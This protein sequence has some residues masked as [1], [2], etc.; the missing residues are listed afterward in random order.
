MVWGSKAAKQALA[1][2]TY[3]IAGFGKPSIS[4]YQLSLPVQIRFGNPTSLSITADQLIAYIYIIKNNSYVIGARIDQKPVTIAAGTSVQPFVVKV[5]LK[6]IFGGNVFNTL[7]F[8]QKTIA[9]K[10]IPIRA[11]VVVVYQG[12]S[13]PKQTF[14]QTVPI[15]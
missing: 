2:F 6:S 9:S 5:D 11:D 4:N 1:K 15:S 13:L 12:I 14:E 8:V 10:S 3:E 7:D